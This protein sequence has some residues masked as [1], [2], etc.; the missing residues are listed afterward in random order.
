VTDPRDGA[1]LTPEDERAISELLAGLPAEPLPPDVADRIDAAL[2][3]EAAERAAGEPSPTV[4]PLAAVPSQR[5]RRVRFLE[6][7]AGVALLGGAVL[8]G[9]NVLG[10]SESEIAAAP[11][12]ATAVQV[13]SSGTAYTEEGFEA[14]LAVL[15][16]TVARAKTGQDAAASA[17]DA[18]AIPEPVPVV[19]EAYVASPYALPVADLEEC[20]GALN[21]EEAPDVVDAA[22]Y[23]AEP[24]LVVVYSAIAGDWDVFAV[25]VD[26]SA[27]DEHLL[28]YQRVR[29]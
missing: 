21:P 22:S 25:G 20:L 6:V 19:S 10:D 12:A 11:E 8:I 26:C 23:E 4:V 28:R 3:R 24:A 17:P 16:P 1:E 13:V 9:V 15:E 7:A 29:D 14:E 18:P 2:R 27:E 5:S